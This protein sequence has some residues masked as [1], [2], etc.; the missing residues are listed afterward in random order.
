MG[1]SRPELLA[2][3]DELLQINYTKIELCRTGAVYCQITTAAVP[4][5]PF[6]RLR[7]VLLPCISCM[8]AWHA[9]PHA[10][11][12]AHLARPPGCP[13]D[14]PVARLPARTCLTYPSTRLPSTSCVGLASRPPCTPAPCMRHTCPHISPFDRTPASRGN[15]PSAHALRVW[16]LRS[17]DSAR[18]PQIP[19]VSMSRGGTV[20]RQ[21]VMPPFFF[22]RLCVHQRDGDTSGGQRVAPRHATGT[23]AGS[24][25]C[26]DTR[27]RRL[28]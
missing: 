3:L 6:A 25:L 18:H 13:P 26:H 4:A 14:I 5:R 23:R 27:W 24:A 12:S 1:E 11:S 10:C 19:H 2:W 17:E 20:T 21:L 15:P 7:Y 16:A 22:T 28:Y 8:P 9:H